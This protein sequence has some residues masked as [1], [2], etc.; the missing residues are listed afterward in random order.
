MENLINDEPILWYSFPLGPR[1]A[2]IEYYY[3]HANPDP[4]TQE[5]TMDMLTSKIISAC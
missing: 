4:R 2:Y 3:V 1:C 5:N